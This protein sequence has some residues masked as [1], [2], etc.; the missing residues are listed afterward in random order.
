MAIF[1]GVHK[2]PQGMGEMQITEG[3][4]KYKEKA[5]AKGLHPIG[6]VYSME[7]GFAYC[8]T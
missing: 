5:V 4:A 3:F 2:I 6:A 1:L 7:K 8:Q